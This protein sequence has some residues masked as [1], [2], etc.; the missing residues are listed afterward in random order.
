MKVKDI[1]SRDIDVDV[2]SDY[3]DELATAFVGPIRLTEE[4]EKEFYEA[5]NYDIDL[6]EKEG[7][8]IVHCDNDRQ[9]SKASHFFNAAAGWCSEDDY[10][11]WFE[12]NE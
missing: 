6:N 10:D 8:C 2:Y 3:T 7:C 5:L 9:L 4:G 1:I 12:L 11:K